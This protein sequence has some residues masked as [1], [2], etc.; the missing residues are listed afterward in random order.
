MKNFI[1][2]IALIVL[3]QLTVSCGQNDS[4]DN[5][6]D[7]NIENAIPDDEM[8]YPVELTDLVSIT[9]VIIYGDS[10]DADITEVSYDGLCLT[11][12]YWCELSTSIEALREIYEND[13]IKGVLYRALYADMSESYLIRYYSGTVSYGHISLD[14][15]EN[16]VLI[17]THLNITN[18]DEYSHIL[19]N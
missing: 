12:D 3:T 5:S 17:D 14:T 8:I 16:S 7:S 18:F 6:F 13:T 1:L 19:F 10:N 2:I 15:I 11:S 9:Q 4:I